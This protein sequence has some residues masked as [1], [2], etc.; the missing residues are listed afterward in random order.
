VQLPEVTVTATRLD[1]GPVIAAGTTAVAQGLG[2]L[3]V[4]LGGVLRIAGAGVVAAMPVTMSGDGPGSQML[5]NE[6]QQSGEG[7][8]SIDSV[9]DLVTEA[10]GEGTGE[11]DVRAPGGKEA[12]ERLFDRA[13]EPGGRRPI[14]DKTGGGRG[15]AGT[16][17][18][19]TPIRIRHKPDGTTRIQAGKQ[20][21]IFP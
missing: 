18:D 11:G 9:D 21:I 15:E 10:G 2:R 5:K 14:S 7:S 1:P 6:G 8:D 19:G 16:M 13:A 17:R 3:T 12:A 4:S 20:K